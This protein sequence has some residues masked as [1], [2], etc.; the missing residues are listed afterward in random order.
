M[1]P[2]KERL[3][4]DRKGS[5]EVKARKERGNRRGLALVPSIYNQVL[6]CGSHAPIKDAEAETNPIRERAV[7]RLSRGRFQRYLAT[8][9]SLQAVA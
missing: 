7:S 2:V 4:L 3:Q 5:H 6:G 9:Y 8:V 1:G